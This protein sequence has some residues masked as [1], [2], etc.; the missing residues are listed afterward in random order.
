MHFMAADPAGVAAAGAALAVPL[1]ERQ[2]DRRAALAAFQP[3]SR[4]LSLVNFFGQ[5]AHVVLPSTFVLYATYRYGWDTKT[6]GLTLAMVGICAMV[7]Q[8]AGVGPIV[9]ASAS[10]AR[11]CSDWAVARSAS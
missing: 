3:G 10:A 11:C 2:S 7:V 1:E 9:S 8:G 5:V 4:R 6:V